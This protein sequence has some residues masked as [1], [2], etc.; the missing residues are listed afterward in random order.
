[1]RADLYN[2]LAAQDALDGFE[3][4]GAE[5]R[6]EIEQTIYEKQG[7]NYPTISASRST[8]D[9]YSY[10]FPNGGVVTYNGTLNTENIVLC[11]NPEDTLLY[12]YD[13]VSL[14]D[15]ITA[16]L[17][18]VP[19]TQ[20]IGHAGLAKLSLVDMAQAEI[21]DAGF[22]AKIIF[23]SWGSRAEQG[24]YGYGWS[25]HPLCT[26]YDVNQITSVNGV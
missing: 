13:H 26:V 5:L 25:T 9:T 11:M 7:V 17:G 10:S 24:T 1:M 4:F 22:Y 20:I 12:F 21:N 18:F 19:G 2:Q 8:G 15:Y 16:V 23:I 3:Y 14:S 6:P